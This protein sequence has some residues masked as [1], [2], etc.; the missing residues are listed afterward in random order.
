MNNS[1]MNTPQ[2]VVTK[3]AANPALSPNQTPTVCCGSLLIAVFRPMMKTSLTAIGRRKITIPLL[4]RKI[5]NGGLQGY[6]QM[7]G[8]PEPKSRKEKIFCA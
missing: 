5:R 8:L 6:M 4:L 3:I 7:K 2:K 1:I